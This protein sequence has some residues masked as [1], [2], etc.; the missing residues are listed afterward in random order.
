M[1]FTTA[2]HRAAPNGN[3]LSIPAHLEALIY[4][5]DLK[6]FNWRKQVK[7][8]ERVTRQVE[9]E[10]EMQLQRKRIEEERK[11][12]EK[13][14]KFEIDRKR[15]ADFYNKAQLMID[16]DS[17][18]I[19]YHNKYLEHPMRAE[20]II[21]IFCKAFDIP[22]IELLEFTRKYAIVKKRQVL[23]WILKKSGKQSLSGIGRRMSGRDHS[24]VLHAVRKVD[25]TPALLELAEEM[26][27]TVLFLEREAYGNGY[28]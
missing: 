26:Q 24:T 19:T 21:A 1:T 15:N 13:I 10:K 27:A 8:V 12:R 11:R 4:K 25:E 17:G 7:D 16:E 3:R 9:R 2:N 28:I 20:R 5:P 22:E 23:M 14:A 6:P 18:Q